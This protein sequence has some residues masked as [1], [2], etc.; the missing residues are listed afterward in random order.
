M[1]VELATE[2]GT[3]GWPNEDFAAGARFM[4]EFAQGRAAFVRSQVA[5]AGQ[6]RR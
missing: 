2:P 3:P 1:R 5:A 4:L 6:R